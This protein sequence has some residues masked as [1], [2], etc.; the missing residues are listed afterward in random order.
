M[1]DL[2]GL[3]DLL[4]GGDSIAAA[5]PPALS[6]PPPP[7]QLVPLPRLAPPQFQQLWEALPVAATF[8]APLQPSGVAATQANHLVRPLSRS[9]LH[10]RV[11]MI[12]GYV[13]STSVH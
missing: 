9:R 5:A 10:P 6:P 11:C 8:R 4:G 1:A 2:L 12:V 3:D 7:L 13:V